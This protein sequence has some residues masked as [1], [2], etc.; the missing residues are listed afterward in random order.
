MPIRQAEDRSMKGGHWKKESRVLLYSQRDRVGFHRLAAHALTTLRA[1]RRIVH[2]CVCSRRPW[3]LG[4][5]A[6]E[7][8]AR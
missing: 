7:D 4:T 5:V 6:F 3:R 2:V 1:E 8:K